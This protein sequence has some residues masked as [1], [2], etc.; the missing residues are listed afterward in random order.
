MIEVV[1][2]IICGC[3][4]VCNEGL[5]FVDQSFVIVTIFGIYILECFT[6]LVEVFLSIDSLVAY[7]M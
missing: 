6:D 5:C 2:V 3:R 7:S 1:G 4:V